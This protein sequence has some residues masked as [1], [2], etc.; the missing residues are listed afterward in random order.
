MRFD[1]VKLVVYDM[2]RMIGFYVEVLGFSVVLEPLES[3]D[4]GLLRA[5]GATPGSRF[6]VALLNPPGGEGPELEFYAMVGPAAHSWP[7]SS[8]QGQL[9]IRV[10]DVE[11]TVGRVVDNGGSMLGEVDEWRT[12]SG[13]V[14]RLVF[15]RDPEGNLLDLFGPAV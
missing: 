12:P 4:E 9:G 14:A 10:D 13:R 11:A 2:D 15:A 3:G 5:I 1:H 7:F 8:G 6:R